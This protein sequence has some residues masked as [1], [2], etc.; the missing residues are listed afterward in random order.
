MSHRFAL[1]ST[2]C[3]LKNPPSAWLYGC[4]DAVF[5]AKRADDVHISV[6]RGERVSAWVAVVSGSP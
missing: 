6:L 4:I 3:V 1:A 2:S 5:G